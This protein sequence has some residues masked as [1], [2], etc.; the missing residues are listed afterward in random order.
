MVRPVTYRIVDCPDGRFAVVAVA[1]SGT[2]YRRGGLLSLAEAEACVEDL[3]TTLASCGTP[4]L[5]DG[6]ELPHP[7]G[8]GTMGMPRRP[9]R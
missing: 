4:L 7:G 5:R 3:R 6:D 1:A 9:F 8:R 2:A